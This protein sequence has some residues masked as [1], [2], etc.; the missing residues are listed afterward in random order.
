MTET[1]PKNTR[2][3][4][5]T[6]RTLRLIRGTGHVCLVGTLVLFIILGIRYPNPYADVWKLV[7]A[8]IT[9]GRVANAA[10]GIKMGFNYTFL[11]YQ[12]FIQDAIL[13]FYVYP[14]FVAGYRHLTHWPFIGASLDKTRELALKHKSWVAPYGSFGLMLFVIFPL[15]S[16]GPL[17]GV[18][19]GYLLGMSALL[20]FSIVLMANFVAVGS[21]I[22]FYDQLE[23]Y[24]PS[25]AWLVVIIVVAAAVGGTLYSWVARKRAKKTIQAPSLVDE[26]V[27]EVESTASSA[28]GDEPVP[29]QEDIPKEDIR[30]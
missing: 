22:W 9:A 24:S 25:L 8:H 5:P 6:A 1:S 2:P 17:V 23:N 29:R 11:V 16:T 20:T 15:W 10:V 12:S 7:L 3:G 30:P 21:W 13:L 28:Q 27:I 26:S 18:L 4:E 19:I 14:W